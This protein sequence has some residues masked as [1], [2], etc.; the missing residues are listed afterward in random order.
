MKIYIGIDGGGTNLKALIGD[1]NKRVIGTAKSGPVNYQSVGIEKVKESFGSLLAYCKN[2]LKIKHEDIECIC[3]GCAGI[4]NKMDEMIYKEMMNELGYSNKLLLYNDAFVAL[5]G[6]NGKAE[7]AVIISGTGSIAYG[8]KKDGTHV[9]VGGWGHIIGDEGSG[10]SIARDALNTIV[11]SMDGII[12]YTMLTEAIMEKLKVKTLEEL[13]TYIYD[14]RT[15]KQHIGELAPVVMDMAKSDKAAEN[16]VKNAAYQ[17]CN[18]VYAL[19]RKMNLESFKLALSG[20]V[21]TKSEVVRNIL[22]DQLKQNSPEIHVSLG[23][24]EPV[25]GALMLAWKEAAI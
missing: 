13:M 19:K 5:V 8:I 10:Y 22:I 17:L 15:Q 16:I 1:S 14:P 9:R 23:E 6:A 24:K 11:R 4:N 20:S 18:M 21:L 7:G 25:Y 12:P 3:M 2:E